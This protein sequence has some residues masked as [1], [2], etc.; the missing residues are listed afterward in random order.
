MSDFKFVM[1]EKED[2]VILLFYGHLDRDNAGVLEQ[3]EEQLK[4]KSQPF[5]IINLRDLKEMTPAVHQQF[6]KLQKTLRDAKKYIGLCGIHPEVK[7]L[8]AIQGIIRESETFNN[9]PD[10]W[11]MLTSRAAANAEA[12]AKKAAKVKKAA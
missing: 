7:K 9:I 12:E 11:Q 4:V 3:L 10:A 1:G 6:A 5:I 2:V 8:L